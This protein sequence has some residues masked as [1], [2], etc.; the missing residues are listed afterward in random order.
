MPYD[1]E[2]YPP[3]PMVSADHDD[4]GVPMH[5]KKLPAILAEHP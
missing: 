5:P 2:R 1:G 3:I 4:R